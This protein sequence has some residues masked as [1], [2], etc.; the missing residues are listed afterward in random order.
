MRMRPV[1][2]VAIS[3]RTQHDDNGVDRDVSDLR[4]TP[5]TGGLERL[6]LMRV[7]HSTSSIDTSC[8]G[9]W[10]TCGTEGVALLSIAIGTGGC[11]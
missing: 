6:F 10:L 1:I 11:A 7:M 8:C 4:Y 9:M 5:D 2:L 3:Y